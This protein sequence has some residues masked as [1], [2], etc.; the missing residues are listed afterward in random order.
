MYLQPGI[1]R[2]FWRFITCVFLA[3]LVFA[4]CSGNLKMGG[5]NSRLMI[6]A[7]VDSTVA[8]AADS[9]ADRLFVS[10]EQEKRADQH[11]AIG[12]DKAAEGDTLWKYLESDATTTAEIDT[13]AAVEA[14]NRGARNLQQ[15]ARLQSEPGFSADLQKA[16]VLQLLEEARKHF[17]R[18][19]ILNPFDSETKS[20]LVKVYQTLAARFLDE[21]NNKRAT[22][23]LEN[24]VRLER[25][26]HTLFARLAESYYALQVWDKA[27][28]NFKQ[29]EDVLRNASGL[30][31]TNFIEDVALDTAALFYYVYYQGD[32]EIKLHAAEAG[33]ASLRRALAYASTPQEL[34]D[35]HSYIDWINWDDGNTKAVELRD[36]YITMQEE[37]NHKDAAKGFLQLIPKLR[38]RRAIDETV[39]RLAV[40]EFQYLER[41][42]AGIDRLKHVVKL[43]L[44]DQNNAP[45]D[46][47]YQRYF[48]SYGVMCHNL[49]LENYKKNRKFAFMYF[50]QS[51]AVAWDSRAKSHLEIAKL[52]RNNPKEVIA[53]CLSALD[54][55]WQLDGNEQMQTYQ[56]LVEALKRTGRF[57][58]A[59]AYY[60]QWND[61]RRNPSRGS[62]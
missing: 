36:K 20:W 19:V 29:A 22:K 21:E 57:D 49:G 35:I 25:G 32:T 13:V 58:E 8:I 46:T 4:G 5:R 9:T 56:L 14:F 42:N 40:L 2:R 10:I 43:T 28:R 17:E 37:G 16:E 38:T 12:K 34:A 15:L 60:A 6:P 18:A 62:N 23:V 30:N 11:K 47:T 61:L 31:F 48:D 55:P 53:S 7:G 39:W 50:K 52:S 51:T 59:R 44:K 45:I 41:K 3:V 26:E 54:A 24:L 33:L 27:N 1:H